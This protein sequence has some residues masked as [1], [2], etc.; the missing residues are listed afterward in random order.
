MMAMLEAIQESQ[1]R[2]AKSKKCK[3]HASDSSSDSDSEQETGSIDTGLGRD[4][5][6]KLNE[7]IDQ[8]LMSTTAHPIKVT[9]IACPD[10]ERSRDTGNTRD[11]SKTGRVT[12]VVV[13]MM[14]FSKHK[15]LAQR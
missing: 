2:A 10:L 11:I 8:N 6:L 9:N 4:K 7:P 3:R 15:K 14:I 1:K 13:M 5:H 12:V